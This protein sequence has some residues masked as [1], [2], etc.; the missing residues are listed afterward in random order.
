[1][2]SSAAAASSLRPKTRKLPRD[3]GQNTRGLTDFCLFSLLLQR[4]HRS[5]WHEYKHIQAKL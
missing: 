2:L 5:I 4:L 3:M 1:M